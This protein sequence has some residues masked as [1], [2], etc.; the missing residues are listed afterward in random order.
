MILI[1]EDQ[2]ELLKIMLKM[3]AKAG[4]EAVAAATGEEGLERCAELGAA[5]RLLLVDLCL[6]G[7]DGC[8]MVARSR[9]SCSAPV[10]FMSG[11]APQALLERAITSGDGFLKKPISLPD[12]R[13]ALEAH[14]GA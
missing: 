6:P 3:V 2:P 14:L 12:L 9:E 8:E 1:V 10:V 5:L 7:I 4:H 13:G 11:G